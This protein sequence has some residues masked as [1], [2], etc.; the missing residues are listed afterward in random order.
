MTQPVKTILNDIKQGLGVDK[1]V[2][3]FDNDIL[4]HINTAFFKLH[5]L[6]VGPTNGFRLTTGEEQWAAFL[7]T[8]MNIEAVKS[9][10][11]IHTRLLFDPPN[12][13]FVLDAYQRQLN[14]IEW[15]LNVQVETNE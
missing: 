1:V 2:E 10:V 6:G 9:Y 4:M 5:Q 12:T 13:S 14:E 11:L 8:D 15:R 3:F 7:S